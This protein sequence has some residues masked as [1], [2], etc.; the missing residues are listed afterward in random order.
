MRGG[1]WVVL[2]VLVCVLS[3]CIF[4][5]AIAKYTFF[6][7]WNAPLRGLAMEILFFPR[8]VKQRICNQHEVEEDEAV[9]IIALAYYHL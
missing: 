6:V 4:L 5:P 7:M 2:F 8:P 3:A 1:T 9:R